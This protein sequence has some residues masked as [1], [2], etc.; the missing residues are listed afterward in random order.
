VITYDDALT[1]SV[2]PKELERLLQ[3]R[4]SGVLVRS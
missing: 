2:H 3:H 1:V 4:T